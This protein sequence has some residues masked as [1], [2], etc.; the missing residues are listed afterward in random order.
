MKT[1]F[2][3]SQA[4]GTLVDIFIREDYEGLLPDETDIV[5][6]PSKDGCQRVFN[7]ATSSWSY[8]PY[9]P[10][11]TVTPTLEQ[12][13]DKALSQL[14]DNAAN[15]YVAGFWSTANGETLLYDST[16]NDQSNIQIASAVAASGN[17]GFATRFPDGFPIR[18][19][20]VEKGDKEIL[21]LTSPQV[22]QLGIDWIA[23]YKQV[24]EQVWVKQARIKAC[25]SLEDI[26]AL[27]LTISDSYTLIEGATTDKKIEMYIEKKDKEVEG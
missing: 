6:P 17:N 19:R 10:H 1:V 21:H 27:G 3:Y 15:A 12:A 25:Q 24:K 16:I 22:I 23:R 11:M 7:R 20:H 4:D 5:P 18:A 14:D 26:D 8:K 9:V 13:K 2:S